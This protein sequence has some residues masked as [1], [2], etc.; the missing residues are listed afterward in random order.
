MEWLRGVPAALQ[1]TQD[2]IERP[3]LVRG[4]LVIEGSKLAGV[5]T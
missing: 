4:A 1:A 5:P 3:V 2:A